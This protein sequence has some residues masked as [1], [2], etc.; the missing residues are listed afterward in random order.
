MKGKIKIALADDQILFREGIASIIKNEKDFSLII[1]ADNGLDFLSK[2]R[3]TN[4]LPEVLLMDMEMPGMDGMQLND[5]IRKKYP[6]IKVIVLS[7]HAKER[8][9]SRM[10]QAGA[11]GY[12]LKNC[13]R[14]ELITAVRNVFENG[15]YITPNVIQALRS[16]L[17]NAKGI[18]NT[19]SIPV[20]ISQREIE[21]L[22]LI[23]EEFSNAEIA[24]KLFISVRTVDGHRNNLL[25]KTGCHNTAGLVLFAVK[26]HIYEIMN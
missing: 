23:C 7:V 16:P 1:E 18:T 2:L 15:F 17:A 22:K 26:H 6:S 5:E 4:E 20:D 14:E 8:L 19:Q 21:V 11:S 13:N 9:I 25:A 3:S 10:I 24:D 12:L